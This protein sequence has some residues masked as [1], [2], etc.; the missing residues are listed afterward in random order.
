MIRPAIV[1]RFEQPR[2]TTS[3]DPINRDTLKEPPIGPPA[4]SPPLAPAAPPPLPPAVPP[5]APKTETSPPREV[6]EPPVPPVTTDTLPDEVVLRLIE[7]GRAAFV[8]CFKKAVAADPLVVSFK[9]RIHVE[10]DRDGAITSATADTSDTSLATC[11]TRAVR[12]LRFPASGRP[13]A[14]DLPLFYRAE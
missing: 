8:R 5:A 10:L 6:L 4:V 7:T 14:A 13:V 1:S 11:L 12:Y 9:V 3:L 2:S